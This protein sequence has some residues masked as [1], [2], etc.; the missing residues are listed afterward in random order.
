MKTRSLK[1]IKKNEKIE[2]KKKNLKILREELTMMIK[3]FQDKI[4]EYNYRINKDE[5]DD[6]N[7]KK[8]SKKIR[9]KKFK[10]RTITKKSVKINNLRS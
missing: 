6:N 4:Q 3:N 1:K 9:K 10:N 7:F 2:F 5:E 8:N